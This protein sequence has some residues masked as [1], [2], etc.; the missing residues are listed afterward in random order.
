MKHDFELFHCP[1]LASLHLLVST[2]PGPSTTPPNMINIIPANRPCPC[3]HEEC[4]RRNR[5]AMAKATQNPIAAIRAI[6]N[7]KPNVF[8]FTA[9]ANLPLA[10]P[11]LIYTGLT[12]VFIKYILHKY[13]PVYDYGHEDDLDPLWVTPLRGLINILA[14][15]VTGKE[16]KRSADVVREIQAAY[17]DICAVLWR[18]IG[19]LLLPGRQADIHRAHVLQFFSNLARTGDQKKYLVSNSC[20]M[21]FIDMLIEQCTT[22][23]PYHLSYN[24]GYTCPSTGKTVNTPPTQY[25]TSSSSSTPT[26]H[27]MSSIKYS[28]PSL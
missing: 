20:R 13:Q 25:S 26:R 4:I 22:I 21:T 23:Q 28:I 19:L 11:H 8:L 12:T 16:S 3:G 14:V 24:A 18:D 15:I 17:S 10:K 7:G 2:S 9:L 6:S 5:V 27:P 1:A